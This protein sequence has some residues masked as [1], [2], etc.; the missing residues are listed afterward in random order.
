MFD[1][2][3][4]QD[5]AELHFRLLNDPD[6]CQALLRGAGVTGGSALADILRE[7]GSPGLVAR[8]STPG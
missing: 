5:G 2:L 4:D 6:A 7:T 8:L 1:E 3:L